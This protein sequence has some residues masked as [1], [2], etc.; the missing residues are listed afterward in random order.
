MTKVTY[1]KVC[2]SVWFQRNKSPAE[3]VHHS[4]I[5]SHLEQVPSGES[6]LEVGKN[7]FLILQTCL[8]YIR[9]S[10]GQ[11]SWNSPNSSSSWEPSD[12]IHKTVG[13]FSSCCHDAIQPAQK[14]S[15]SETSCHVFIK[16][17]FK[18]A[19]LSIHPST[20]SSIIFLPTYL[21]VSGS[22]LLTVAMYLTD[23]SW[24]RIDFR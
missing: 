21:L 6:R 8:S 24:G 15:H 4:W 22:C 12:Q 5:S 7:F 13:N 11:T 18:L 17:L 2:L 1:R 9:S 16:Q 20:D 10:D 19:P 14:S 3:W 23:T